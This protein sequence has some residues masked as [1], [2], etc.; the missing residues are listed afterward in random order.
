M[1]YRCDRSDPS[2]LTGSLRGLNAMAA[3]HRYE[4]G[5]DTDGMT[6]GV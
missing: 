5:D 2:G 3:M 4:E 6:D 1:V